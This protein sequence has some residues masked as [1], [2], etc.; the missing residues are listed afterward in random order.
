MHT[1]VATDTASLYSFGYISPIEYTAWRAVFLVGFNGHCE[2]ATQ[3]CRGLLLVAPLFL[4]F[5]PG[6]VPQSEIRR[7]SVGQEINTHLRS[8]SCDCD[9]RALTLRH[10]SQSTGH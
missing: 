9:H 1:S 5:Q 8:G 7:G 6:Y 10:D 4:V 2:I 3:Y